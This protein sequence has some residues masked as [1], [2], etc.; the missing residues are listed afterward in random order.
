M[1]MIENLRHRPGTDGAPIGLTSLPEVDAA[2]LQELLQRPFLGQDPRQAGGMP[3]LR[4]QR[5]PPQ[6]TDRL[7]ANGE[8]L[9]G[10]TPAAVRH[11]RLLTSMERLIF[12]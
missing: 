9:G 2:D 11:Q 1:V 12:A 10:L 8:A 6:T 5:L 4:A 7:T 3:A